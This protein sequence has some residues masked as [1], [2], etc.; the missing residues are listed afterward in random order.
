MKPSHLVVYQMIKDTIINSDQKDTIHK[1]R[2]RADFGSF[3]FCVL[4][5][6][7]GAQH[8]FYR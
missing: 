4:F 1:G 6:R 5:P 7:T 8:C 2:G 3:L